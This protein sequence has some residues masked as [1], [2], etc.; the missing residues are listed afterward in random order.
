MINDQ[1]NYDSLQPKDKI[2]FQNLLSSQLINDVVSKPFFSVEDFY[3]SAW[4][5]FH[6][7]KKGKRSRKKLENK[8]NKTTVKKDHNDKLEPFQIYV[9]TQS[10]L[11]KEEFKNVSAKQKQKILSHEWFK[12]SEV[13]KQRIID[14]N[15]RFAK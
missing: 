11:R 4:E 1:N 3:N 10:K 2:I 8:E 9:K 13:D 15:G 12:I 14:E 7:E 6:E 5:N